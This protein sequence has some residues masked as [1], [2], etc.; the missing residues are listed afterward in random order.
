MLSISTTSTGCFGTNEN[1]RV[2]LY[3]IGKGLKH[4]VFLFINSKTHVV[5]SKMGGVWPASLMSY[6]FRWSWSAQLL[7][8]VHS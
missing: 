4:H 5:L 7:L 3:S 1:Y 6:R 2:F 8:F